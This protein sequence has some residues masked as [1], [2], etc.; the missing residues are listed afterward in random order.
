MVLDFSTDL[1]IA[2]RRSFQTLS[3]QSHLLW[4]V[5]VLV[6]TRLSKI[7][8][9]QSQDNLLMFIPVSIIQGAVIAGLYYCAGRICKGT[10]S[11]S[12]T[13]QVY[14]FAGLP[15]LLL[16]PIGLISFFVPQVIFFQILSSVLMIALN[17]WSLLLLIIGLKETHRVSTAKAIIIVLVPVFLLPLAIVLGITLLVI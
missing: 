6:L 12:L 13:F 5:I 14:S 7:I 9:Q 1:M 11:Y 15:N 10:A 16:A 3:R 8:F 4:A 2:P 17:I